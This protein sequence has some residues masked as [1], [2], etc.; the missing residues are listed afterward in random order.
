MTISRHHPSYNKPAI[1]PQARNTADWPQNAGKIAKTAT[2]V[3]RWIS[4]ASTSTTTTNQLL[5][6]NTTFLTSN[7][8]RSTDRYP[9]IETNTKPP[10]LSP[11]SSQITTFL[12]K[13]H[14]HHTH[15]SEIVQIRPSLSKFT[16]TVAGNPIFCL[17]T[18]WTYLFHL[19]HYCPFF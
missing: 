3:I 7:Q 13:N 4:H 17:F 9:E 5:S 14:H 18:V 15:R 11:N 1:E 8:R 10:L 16:I 19:Y 6:T 2:A 12:T